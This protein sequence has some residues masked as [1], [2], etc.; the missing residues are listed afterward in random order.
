MEPDPGRH[1]VLAILCVVAIF[2]MVDRQIITIVLDPIKAE[3]GASD[4][5][6]GAGDGRRGD[7]RLLR[8]T[9]V[10]HDQSRPCA[11]TEFCAA[12]V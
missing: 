3:F 4:T 2:N 12:G 5:A 6:M 9:R 11:T 7:C 1:F 10:V 8:F